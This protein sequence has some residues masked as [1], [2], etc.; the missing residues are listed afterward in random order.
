MQA[1]NLTKSTTEILEQIVSTLKINKDI[2][3][4]ALEDI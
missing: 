1:H 2:R 4:M 3:V